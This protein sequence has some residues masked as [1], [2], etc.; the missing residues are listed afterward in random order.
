MIPFYWILG[1]KWKLS[2]FGILALILLPFNLFYTQIMTWLFATFLPRYL[3]TNYVTR[4]FGVTAMFLGLILLPMM[5]TVI[6][7]KMN[8]ENIVFKNCMYI[9]VLLV[10]F[11]SWLPEYQRFVYYFFIPSIVYVPYLLEEDKNK[12]RKYIFYVVLLAFYALYFKMTFSQWSI[13]PYQSVIM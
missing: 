9:S 10:L 7:E 1:K 2:A 4:S 5:I 11:G 12:K 8:E 3:N 13:A 6:Y